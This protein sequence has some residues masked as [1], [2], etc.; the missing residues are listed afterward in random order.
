[1]TTGTAG[2]MLD[3]CQLSELLG[4]T[5]RTTE[6]QRQNGSGPP[7]I[8]TGLRHVR[9][10]RADVDAWIAGRTFQHRAAEVTADLAA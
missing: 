2:E 9:Y 7:Y 1:M 8:R 6:R 4:Q 3:T 10:R 5:V